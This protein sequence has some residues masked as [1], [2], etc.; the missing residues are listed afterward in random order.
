M[1]LSLNVYVFVHVGV[2][3]S[4]EEHI[5]EHIPSIVTMCGRDKPRAQNCFNKKYSARVKNCNRSTV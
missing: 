4:E 5:L 2:Y 3:I 1:Y